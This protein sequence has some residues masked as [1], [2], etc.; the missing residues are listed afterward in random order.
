MNAIEDTQCY[1]DALSLFNQITA[2]SRGYVTIWPT[3]RRER[4]RLNILRYMLTMLERLVQQMEDAIEGSSEQS[5]D[6]DPSQL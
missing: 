3:W 1:Q 4:M 6:E 2:L 5:E